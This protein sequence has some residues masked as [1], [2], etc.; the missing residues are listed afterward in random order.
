[1]RDTR[2]VLAAEPFAVIAQGAVG[3]SGDFGIGG[4]IMRLIV[5]ELVALG[6]K[7]FFRLRLAGALQSEGRVGNRV[8]TTQAMRLA[9]MRN[10]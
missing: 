7:C 3:L 4:P 8:L 5:A 9:A 2:L 10:M 6:V 1:M